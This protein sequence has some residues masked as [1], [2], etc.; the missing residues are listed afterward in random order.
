MKWDLLK[1]IDMVDFL[2]Y[3]INSFGTLLVSIFSI[4]VSILNNEI[5]LVE[6]NYTQIV[7]IPKTSNVNSKSSFR[8]MNLCSI[9]YKIISNMLAN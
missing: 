2:P 7:L 8:P 5:P 3:F 6:I 4:F 1:P 9:L